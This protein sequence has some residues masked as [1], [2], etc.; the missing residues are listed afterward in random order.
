MR[1]RE[2]FING[3]KDYHRDGIKKRLPAVTIA[4]KE[5]SLYLEHLKADIAE[6]ISKMAKTIEINVFYVETGTFGIINVEGAT[7]QF[8]RLP[9]KIEIWGDKFIM[10]ERFYTEQYKLAEVKSKIDNLDELM[11]FVMKEVFAKGNF[12]L[13]N[14][15]LELI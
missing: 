13:L 3:V 1:Y 4:Q 8:V 6:E 15:E 7:L 14:G 2:R 10:N 12:G 9:K 11:D 5:I